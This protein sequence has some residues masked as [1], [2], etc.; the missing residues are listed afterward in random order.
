M[1]MTRVQAEVDKQDDMLDFSKTD[2]YR[3]SK[4]KEAEDQTK[5][6]TDQKDSSQDGQHMAACHMILGLIPS[7]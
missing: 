7:V 6:S 1:N 2:A 3:S 5:A 4:A